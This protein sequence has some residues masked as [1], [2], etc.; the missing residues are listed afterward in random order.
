MKKIVC[1]LFT[2]IIASVSLW[3]ANE[4]VSIKASA[5]NV[6]A[7][8]QQFRLEFNIKNAKPTDLQTPEIK[9]FDILM[10]PSTSSAKQVSII[11][12]AMTTTENLTYTYILTPKKEGTFT[13]SP[14][15]F[16]YNGKTLMS[17]ALTIKVVAQGSNTGGGQS[18]NGYNSGNQGENVTG[19]S[20][21][22]LFCVA[23]YNKKKV[24]EGEQLVTTIKL[25]HKGNVSGIDNVKFP[26]YNGFIAQEVNIKDEERNAGIETYNGARYYVYILKKAILF[27][28]RANNIDIENGKITV[29]AQVQ[30]RSSNRRRSI[31]DMDDFFGTT[32][33]VKKELTI[34]GTKIEVMPLPSQGKPDNFNGT[35]GSYRIETSINST[36][37]KANDAIN[38]KVKI[39][40]TGNIKYVKEP[41][42]K[43]PNDFEIYDPKV[44][45]KVSTS[46][47]IVSG[48][49]EI[50]Y[51]AIP[52]Y[53]GVYEIPAADFS[54]FDPKTKRYVSLKTQAYTINVAKGE[55]NATENTTVVS[56]FG[57][58]ENVKY[59]GKDIHFI[60]K[61]NTSLSAYNTP[62][63]GST[64]FYLWFIIPLCIFITLFILYRKQL[65]EN[66]NIILVKNKRANKQATKRLKKAQQHLVANEKEQFY[67]E[68]LKALWGYTS[69]KLNI[70]I[71]ELDKDN[72]ES[73]LAEH[74]IDP[75]VISNFMNVLQ[76][77]E[78]A[79]FAPTNG[80]EA[81]DELYTKAVDLISTIEEQ[82]KI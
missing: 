41:E 56:N 28:Q 70:P 80:Q 26:E 1:V 2:F 13:I 71:A 22:D 50:E 11:N 49:K 54:F 43:F 10:G 77:C 9:D 69:D 63:F 47:N 48:T 72:I 31:F 61:K 45:S 53:A 30:K 7:I 18:T 36:E 12:G 60:N 25:Y 33:N 62:F 52:R 51:L 65:K 6:V 32:Y 27:P 35:V 19:V 82:I 16:T 38:L 5:P 21:T 64:S 58:K 66:A 57:N 42:I 14:A 79:R 68:V 17:N 74:K 4:D 3:A 29:V 75:T 24:Y 55:N 15:R 39:S 44:N 78:F 73:K 67:E 23:E 37:V 8:G 81:M 46:G 59:L 76:T 20:D 34:K 40:G